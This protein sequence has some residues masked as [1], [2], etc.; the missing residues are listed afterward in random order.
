MHI[1][2]KGNIYEDGIYVDLSHWGY[3]PLLVTCWVADHWCR[4][5]VGRDLGSELPS[6]ASWWA[7]GDQGGT[8]VMVKRFSRG[9]SVVLKPQSVLVLS[10]SNNQMPA[11]V[12]WTLPNQ[13]HSAHCR[14]ELPSPTTLFS[15]AIWLPFLLFFRASEEMN[16]SSSCSLWLL[17]AKKRGGRKGCSA[18]IH[19][20]AEQP[21]LEQA[22]CP[23]EKY[24]PP[25]RQ[26]LGP[27]ILTAE[28]SPNQCAV[29]VIS[30]C[31]LNTPFL[32]TDPSSWWRFVVLHNRL[33][34]VGL[35]HEFWSQSEPAPELHSVPPQTWAC[36]DL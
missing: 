27:C 17:P 4:E 35:L 19:L 2:S 1:F 5:Q 22:E 15:T 30:L 11:K 34:P 21:C 18:S 16:D 36:W 3:P 32:S 8:W 23:N 28:I 6:P 10:S 14:D 33:Y 24:I 29:S 31:V 7:H 26:C 20:G 12:L 9:R 13:A 25:L